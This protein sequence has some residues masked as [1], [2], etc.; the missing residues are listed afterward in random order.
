MAP[1]D[2]VGLVPLHQ[3]GS[4]A[5]AMARGDRPDATDQQKDRAAT[6]SGCSS[7]S[8]ERRWWGGLG[9]Q[10]YFKGVVANFDLVSI[11]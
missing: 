4:S 3:M 10:G 9:G 8:A 7:K 1:G 2:S 5:Q 11:S 6:H